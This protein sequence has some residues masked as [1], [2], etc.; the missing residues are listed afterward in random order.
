MSWDKNVLYPTW[1][2]I[3]LS[4]K[5]YVITSKIEESNVMVN[6]GYKFIVYD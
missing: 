2:G 1:Q 6:F 4:R 5:G 3:L